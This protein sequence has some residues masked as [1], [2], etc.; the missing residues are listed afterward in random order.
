[1]QRGIEQQGLDAQRAQF[2]EARNNPYKMLQF[3]QSML[4]GLPITGQSYNMS[5]PS[6][7]QQALSGAGGLA[8]L[9]GNKS[10]LTMDDLSASLKKLGINI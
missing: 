5:Q 9:F 1:M 6:G 2:E 4:S 8:G 10:S 7:F 3:Q